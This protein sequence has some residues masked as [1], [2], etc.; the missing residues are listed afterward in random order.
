MPSR[1]G[2]DKKLGEEL[3]YCPYCGRILRSNVSMELAKLRINELRHYESISL[4]TFGIGVALLLTYIKVTYGIS[5]LML[6][7]IGFITTVSGFILSIYFSLKRSKLTRLI[8]EWLGLIELTERRAKERI[9]NV[10]Q[11]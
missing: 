2:C 11:T 5:D 3:S 7:V 9:Q 4:A 1:P 10:H 6:I 8:E